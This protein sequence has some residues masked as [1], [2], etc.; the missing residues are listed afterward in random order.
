MSAARA[1][2]SFPKK[3]FSNENCFVK[4]TKLKGLFILREG[5][6]LSTNSIK[7]KQNKQTNQQ[8]KVPIA[9]QYRINNPEVRVLGFGLILTA[10]F[11]RLSEF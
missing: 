3:Y 6:L 5:G 9:S 10:K 11:L 7:N 1:L 4:Q 2:D 8:T